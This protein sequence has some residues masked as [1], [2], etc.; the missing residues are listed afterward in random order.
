MDVIEKT[1]KVGAIMA[2]Y[3]KL[4]STFRINILKDS[5][6][7]SKRYVTLRGSVILNKKRCWYSVYVSPEYKSTPEL[8]EK[9]KETI[10]SRHLIFINKEL[11]SFN[12]TVEDFYKDDFKVFIT[13]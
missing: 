8:I 11:S 5:K 9:A 12:L 3:K 7:K 4:D 1:I 13:I 6:N 10:R 2:A